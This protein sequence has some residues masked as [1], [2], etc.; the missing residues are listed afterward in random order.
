MNTIKKLTAFF[1]VAILLF[2]SCK[3]DSVDTSRNTFD[4]ID[5]N[6]YPYIQ[7]GTQTWSQT[8]LSVS[9]YRNGDPIPQVT[10][11]ATWANLTTG[12]WCWYNNDSATYGSIYGKLYNWYAVNDS[13]GLAPQSWHIPSDAEWNKLTK[14]L[15][16]SAD[17][18]E[19]GTCSNVAGGAMKSI[20]GW[21]E[22]NVGATNS[23]GFS[24]I[25][26]GFRFIDCTFITAG[27]FGFWWSSS[28]I[29]TTASWCRFLQNGFSIFGR[30][31]NSNYYG[32]S[33]RC[34]RD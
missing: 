20:T 18:T 15:D 1:F 21:N 26:G 9:R 28:E 10:D 5:G 17:T 2:V 12:A 6:I 29:V 30:D 33:V 22:P 16:P 27:D 7:I 11:S 4:D 31:Y 13:R 24:G 14:F 19:L 8:N 32:F 34:I 23:S 3:K 25:P